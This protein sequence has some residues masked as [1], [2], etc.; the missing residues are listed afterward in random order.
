MSAVKILAPF[1]VNTYAEK[2]KKKKKNR[3][4]KIEILD[5]YRAMS[6]FIINSD[7]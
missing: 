1:T 6:L 7:L 2:K 3:N 4:A 5:I